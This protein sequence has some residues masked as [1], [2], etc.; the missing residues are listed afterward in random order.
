[1]T[2]ENRSKRERGGEEKGRM[3]DDALRGRRKRVNND[4]DER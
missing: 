3:S 1:M 4:I 2:E